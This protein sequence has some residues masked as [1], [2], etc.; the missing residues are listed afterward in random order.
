MSEV[1]GSE[2]K[3]FGR[4]ISL[5]HNDSSSPACLACPSSSSSPQQA[6]SAT[7]QRQEDQVRPPPYLFEVQFEENHVDLQI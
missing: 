3:L 4:T 1:K 6:T 2:I 5:P 7:Q